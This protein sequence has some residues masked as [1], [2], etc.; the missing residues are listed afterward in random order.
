MKEREREREDP[1][2]RSKER[3]RNRRNK[4]HLAPPP[5]PPPTITAS[6]IRLHKIK[7]MQIKGGFSWIL[8]RPQRK[9]VQI[10]LSE[11]PGKWA[12]GNKVGSGI[13][14]EGIG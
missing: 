11:Q 7:A 9:L 12:N 8:L 1:D 14:I 4:T 2:M 13:K 3:E 6:T 10:A 5:L